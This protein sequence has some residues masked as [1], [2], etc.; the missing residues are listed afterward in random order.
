M[1]GKPLPVTCGILQ[2]G[3]RILALRRKDGTELGGKWEFPGGKIE[4]GESPEACLQREL[5]E[6][7][8]IEVTIHEP[9]PPLQHVYPHRTILLYPF[10]CSSPLPIESLVDHDRI[11]WGSPE[12]L[13][14]LDWAE[15]DRLVLEA[16]IDRR[17]NHP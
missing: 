10:I 5:K 8:N 6:E 16:Y 7:L 9:L 4:P 14:S 3:D 11:L 12:N 13:R 15:A 1:D 2:R 17:R